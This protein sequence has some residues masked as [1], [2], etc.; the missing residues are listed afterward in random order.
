[1]QKSKSFGVASALAAASM[2]LA[3]CGTQATPRVGAQ[4]EAVFH[5]S[6]QIDPRAHQGIVAILHL[7]PGGAVVALARFLA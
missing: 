1:M 6:G 2:I 3:A 7:P 4:F 5:G